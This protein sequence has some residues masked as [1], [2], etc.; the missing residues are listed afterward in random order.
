MLGTGQR[1]PLPLVRL[2]QTMEKSGN[3]RSLRTSA[4]SRRIRAHGRRKRWPLVRPRT[5]LAA[6][7]GTAAERCCI[8]FRPSA[9]HDGIGR[10]RSLRFDHGHVDVFENLP[11]RDAAGSVG[12]QN[13]VVAGLAGVFATEAIDK[14]EG[15]IQLTGANQEASAIGC[16]FTK[17]SFHRIVIL[18]GRRMVASFN[19]PMTDSPGRMGCGHVLFKHETFTGWVWAL[20]VCWPVA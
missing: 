20:R 2:G 18:R 1:Q 13:Q 16:P 4:T 7:K 3:Y 6:V 14:R 10:L 17:H 19:F 11:G 12:R 9:H 8:V 15:L 5:R